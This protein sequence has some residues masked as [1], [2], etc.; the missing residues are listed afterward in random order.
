MVFFAFLSIRLCFS[1]TFHANL[2]KNGVFGDTWSIGII[3]Y[4]ICAV[5]YCALNVNICAKLVPCPSKLILTPSLA[6]NETFCCPSCQTVSRRRGRRLQSQFAKSVVLSKFLEWT[7]RPI[8]STSMFK[9][10]FLT[11]SLKSKVR[12]TVASL[13]AVKRVVTIVVFSLLIGP[14]YHL[15][16]GLCLYPTILNSITCAHFIP[17]VHPKY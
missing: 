12:S 1:C 2:A 7:H 6:P 9:R 4:K 10:L 8:Y 11:G 3:I 17:V 15:T 5:I 14:S 13:S 16:V